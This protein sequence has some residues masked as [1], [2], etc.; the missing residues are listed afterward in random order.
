MCY[1]CVL[2]LNFDHILRRL[3]F[4][5]YKYKNLV[6][7]NCHFFEDKISWASTFCSIQVLY[8]RIL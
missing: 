7:L 4:T 2:H 1:M 5:C 3:Q 6:E 8:K